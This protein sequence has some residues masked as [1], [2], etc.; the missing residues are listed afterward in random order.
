MTDETTA[1]AEELT[2]PED[3]V[4][5]E[6]VEPDAKEDTVTS[7]ANVEAEPAKAELSDEQKAINKLA[8]EKR[9][10]KR[11]AAALEKENAELKAQANNVDKVAINHE[12]AMPIEA[13]YDFD[14]DK[15]RADLAQYYRDIAVFTTKQTLQAHQD[16]R[17]KE[18]R[19]VQEDELFSS[20]DR[21]VAE[22]GIQ[23]FYTVTANLPEFN[24]NVRTAMM[25]SDNAPNL[26]HYLSQHLDIAESLTGLDTNMAIMQIGGIAERLKK[27]KTT[28]KISNAPDPIEP[29]NQGGASTNERDD[30]LIDGATFI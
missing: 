29:L 12:P 23:D 30:P 13:N 26:V 21:K 14:S 18:K 22:S 5:I 16:T 28:N 15:Y 11:H 3:N 20:F 24:E 25:L 7:D 4:V 2:A 17:L 10:A 1:N 8:F 9:E 27:A 19:A 6:G